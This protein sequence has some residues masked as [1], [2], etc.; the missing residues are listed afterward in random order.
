MTGEEIRKHLELSYDLWTN[1][2]RSSKD[3][4][5]QLETKKPTRICNDMASKNLNI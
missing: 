2:M 4:I 1:T 3:H 5:M